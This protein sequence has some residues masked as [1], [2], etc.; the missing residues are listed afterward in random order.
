MMV[1]FYEIRNCTCNDVDDRPVLVAP[2]GLLLDK[3]TYYEFVLL[4]DGRW[5]HFLTSE[6][7]AHVMKGYPKHEVVFLHPYTC[8]P[9]VQSTPEETARGN[10][11]AVSLGLMIVSAV[12]LCVLAFFW[13]LHDPYPDSLA[14]HL[15]ILP[16]VTQ[17]AAFT[18]VIYAWIHYPENSLVKVTTLIV[19]AET[20]LVALAAAVFYIVCVVACNGCWDAMAGCG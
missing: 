15:F 10:Q 20:I 13:F 17:V 16:A 2:G 5:V 11:F 9:I 18:L 7:Y 4:E 3:L 8:T 19:I 6:E 1:H 14:A 12:L